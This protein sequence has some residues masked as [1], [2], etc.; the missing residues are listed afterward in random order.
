MTRSTHNKPTEHG[1]QAAV[2]E[3]ARM[4]VNIYPALALL[5]AIP[6]GAKLP[7]FKD[8]RGVRKAP[9]AYKLLKEGLLPGVSDLFLPVPM[10]KFHG[11][12]IEMKRDRTAKPTEKQ[13]WWLICVAKQGY[14]A[15][16]CHGQEEAIALLGWYCGLRPQYAQF[17]DQ[18][19]G[20]LDRLKQYKH[21]DEIMRGQ[22]GD[23]V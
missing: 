1:E 12:Y 3:W 13:I 22:N 5:H 23:K 4:Q 17:P 2:M 14:C 18:V 19:Q 21:Y 6:N 16:V 7:Y 10:S 9:Q 20:E 15:R 8:K 11:I